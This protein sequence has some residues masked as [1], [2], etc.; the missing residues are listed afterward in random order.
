MI[1]KAAKLDFI[2]LK[3]YFKSICFTLLIPI[4]FVLL[5]RSLTIG[6]SFAMFMMSMSSIY[7]FSVADKNDMHRLYS[8]L[9][10]SAAEL[11]CGKY[12]HVFLMGILTLVISG[13][14][15]PLILNALGTTVSLQMIFLSVLSGLV[16][17]TTYICVQIPGYYKYGP[18]KGRIFMYVPV[19]GI[20]VTIYAAQKSTFLSSF[21]RLL[22]HNSYLGPCLVL[23]YLVLITTVSV[24]VS[25]TIYRKK[26]W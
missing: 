16:L 15:Q 8:V 12:V 21:L 20:L 7:T 9:P 1:M 24:A 5:Y 6:I 4:I 10:V 13:T 2:L 18:I 19:I 25:V 11:V 17:F 26:E 22:E 3:Y 23:V 14:V